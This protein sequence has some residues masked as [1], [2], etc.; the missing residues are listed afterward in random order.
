MIV[1]DTLNMTLNYIIPRK[2]NDSRQGA[3]NDIDEVNKLTICFLD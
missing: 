1:L 3:R 2:L